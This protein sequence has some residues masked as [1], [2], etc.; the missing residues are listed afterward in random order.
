R[1][2]DAPSRSDSGTGCGDALREARA[3]GIEPAMARPVVMAPQVASTMPRTAPVA[4][5]AASPRAEAAT[6]AVAYPAPAE[7]VAK[8]KSSKRRYL[9][10][11]AAALLCILISCFVLI[12]AARTPTLS[13]S[14]STVTAGD[15]V[16]VNATNVPANQN[17]EIQLRSTLH[18]FA[19]RADSNGRVSVPIVVPRT[20]GAGD[21]TVTICWASRCRNSVTMHVVEPG[22]ALASPTPGSTPGMTPGASPTPITTPGSSPAPTGGTSPRPGP[23]PSPAPKPTPSPTPPPPPP[24][25]PNPSINLGS[26][27]QAPGPTT[28][29]FH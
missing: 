28:M 6:V 18:N 9:I 3:G 10:V 4:A 8:R 16:V 11:A 23:S 17:G 1:R 7:P 25:T 22:V 5:P 27:H 2:R 13:L 21:H 29:P 12:A 19:F 20:I 24:P 15:T 14:S 26:A